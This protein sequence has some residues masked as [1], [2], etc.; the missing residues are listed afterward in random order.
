MPF[1]SGASGSG[2]LLYNLPGIADAIT[3]IQQAATATDHNHTLSINVLTANAQNFGG[4]GS[5]A[6]QHALTLVNQSYNMSQD[7]IAQ[8]GQALGMASDGMQQ[9][10][11]QLAAQYSH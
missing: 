4:Q 9:T 5:V 8:A 11:A 7:A 1:S 2:G 6:F 3:Q 10:D